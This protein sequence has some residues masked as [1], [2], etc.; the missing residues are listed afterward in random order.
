MLVQ[1]EYQVF[2]TVGNPPVLVGV[3]PADLQKGFGHKSY[4]ALVVQ[5]IPVYPPQHE[6][7]ISKSRDLDLE[8]SIWV[9]IILITQYLLADTNAT[10][11]PQLYVF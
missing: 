11:K 8:L 5:K 4:F 3:L 6:K 9:F 1:E 7:L 10:D 2:R